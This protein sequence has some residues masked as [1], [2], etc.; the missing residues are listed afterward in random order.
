MYV[1]K[2][3]LSTCPG[4]SVPEPYRSP[5]WALVPAQTIPRAE[6]LPKKKKVIEKYTTFNRINISYNSQQQKGRLLEIYIHMSV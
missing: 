1:I 5:D 2:L 3:P 4:C 6:Y